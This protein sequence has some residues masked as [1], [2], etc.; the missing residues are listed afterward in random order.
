MARV[1]VFAANEITIVHLM[2][3]TV[4]RCFLLGDDSFS[5]KNFGHRKVYVCGVCGF[6]SHSSGIGGYD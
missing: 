1:E 2:N 6:E 4:R 5:G 3:R